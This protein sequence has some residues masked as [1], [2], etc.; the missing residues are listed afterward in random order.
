MSPTHD[1]DSLNA[2]K[3]HTKAR[4]KPSLVASRLA[5]LRVSEF[6]WNQP[7]PPKI[8]SEGCEGLDIGILSS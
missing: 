1:Y 8:A 7:P 5:G 3:C 2:P 6:S 4:R